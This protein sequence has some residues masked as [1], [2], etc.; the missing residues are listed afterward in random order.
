MF[1]AL[2]DDRFDDHLDG[3]LRRKFVIKSGTERSQPQADR[4]LPLLPE[5]AFRFTED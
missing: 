5:Y 1:N 4:C 2:L 3:S